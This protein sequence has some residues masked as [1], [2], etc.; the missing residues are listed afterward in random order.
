MTDTKTLSSGQNTARGK[1]APE[2]VKGII[3]TSVA[4]IC[5]IAFL[6]LGMI[7][8]SQM[9]LGATY[10]Y[11]FVKFLQIAF[12]AG[13]YRVYDGYGNLLD[14]SFPAIVLYIAIVLFVLLLLTIVFLCLRYTCLKQVKNVSAVAHW[15]CLADAAAFM[16]VYLF[17]MFYKGEVTKLY[18]GETTLYYRAFECRPLILVISLAMAFEAVLEKKI[19]NKTV[20]LIRRFLPIYGFMVIPLAFIFVFNLYPIVIQSVLS[21]KDHTMSGSVWNGEWVGFKHFKTI[22]TDPSMLEVIGRTLYISM[23]R[24]V[25]GIL[26]SLILSICLYDLKSKTMRSIFQNIVYIPHFFSWVVVYAI[27][28]ALL[29]PNGL[30]NTL[31]HG[32]TDYI[33]NEKWFMP[34]VIVT[35]VWKEL[36]WGTILYLAALSGVDISLFEAAKI[37]GASPLQRIWHVTLPGIKSTV[38]FLTV[39]SLGSILKGAGGEQLLLFYSSSTKKQALVIDTWLVWTGL[40]EFKY[41]LGAAMGFFQS[42]IGMIMVLG[43]NYLSKK[44]CDVSMW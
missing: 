35:A 14:V 23:L 25:I 40:K 30:I 24:L 41:S 44:L 31:F 15:V 2:A 22:F 32:S 16:A 26:P 42:A 34:I 3:V 6:F 4:A 21:F 19:G 10:D 13:G 38:V 27:T 39:M 17:L 18:D 28:Y 7:R 1:L 37:D 12:S 11:S 8:K 33:V 29:S 5:L 43:S 9:D 20:G 36:G